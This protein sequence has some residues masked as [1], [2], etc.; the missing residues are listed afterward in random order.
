MPSN[1]LTSLITYA[2]PRKASGGGFTALPA[3]HCPL[4]TT[5]FPYSPHAF[6][7]T[8]RFNPDKNS[9]RHAMLSI[10][11]IILG[12]ASIHLPFSP[13]STLSPIPPSDGH[14]PVTCRISTPT[15]MLCKTEG[16]GQS[17]SLG[18]SPALSNPCMLSST[19]PP[20]PTPLAPSLPTGSAL[21]CLLLRINAVGMCWGEEDGSQ[22]GDHPAQGQ[23]MDLSLYASTFV[24]G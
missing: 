1:A 24:A 19:P 3:A 12:A 18:T 8:C 13:V 23:M 22:T 14:H 20:P 21:L 11:C 6:H 4:S 16:Q 2:Y 7:I 17:G 10:G 9:E 5:N 15:S